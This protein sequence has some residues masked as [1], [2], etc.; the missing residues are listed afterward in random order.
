MKKQAIII[1]AGIAG[2]ATSVR[3]AAKG[4]KVTVMESSDGPGGKLRERVLGGYRFDLG[5]SLFTLPDLVDELFRLCGEEPASHFRYKRLDT[6]CHYFWNDGTRFHASAD[7]DE[8]ARELAS[9]FGEDED[10]VRR[11]ARKSGY[12]YERTAPVFLHQSLHRL[13]WLSGPVW[14]GIASMPFLPF[15]GTLDLLNRRSFRH[16][17]TVQFFN[18]FATYNGSDP[19]QAPAMMML[20]PHLEQG[21]GAYLPEQ[22]MGAISSSIH[23]LASRM[24]VEFRFSEPVTSILR[25]N[26]A[27]QGVE[28][29][30]GRYLAPVV[31]SNADM[32]PTYRLLLEGDS[33]PERLLAQEKS[34]SALIFY[35]G[36]RR[37]FPELGVH[38][39]FFAEDYQAEF[40]AIFR[41]RVSYS[42]PTIYVNIT[43]K[44]VEGD[45]PS[46]CENWFVMINVPHQSGQDWNAFRH[47]SRSVMLKKLSHALGTDI[48]SL[49]EVEDYLDPVLI[50]TRTSS[51]LGALYGN[52][53][54]SPF[55]AFL[56]HAN[57]STRY[58]GLYFCGGSVH[59]GG[60]IPLCLFGARITAELITRRYP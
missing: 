11:Y 7:A 54:N 50:E 35:W 41:Q 57:E 16:P 31:V 58:R 44:E 32:H 33:A 15:R 46:G 22:G 17:K 18:R 43:S 56:R 8:L 55:A 3:L 24:G 40:D 42:D 20:I 53:S 13:K 36:I 34:S 30:R 10:A 49:I 29:A 2:L 1:G 12:V 48:T 9:H 26:G 27:V 38:N 60:G 5:P 23:A 14:K 45:A 6:I 37:S 28:T 39:I 19:Y 51:Y 52:A 59:P 47:E 21:I 4:W 25:E